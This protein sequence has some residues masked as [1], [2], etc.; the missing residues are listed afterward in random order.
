MRSAG[1]EVHVSLNEIGPCIVPKLGNVTAAGMTTNVSSTCRGDRI[2]HCSDS[3]GV[4]LLSPP[5]I[6]L[7][8]QL[9][10]MRVRVVT[11]MIGLDKRLWV[12][13]T[14]KKK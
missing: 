13:L 3:D 14:R 6:R 4:G 11:R 7:L 9:Q 2:L 10:E 12:V 5:T 8:C 1:S